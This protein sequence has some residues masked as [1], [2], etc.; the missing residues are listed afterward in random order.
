MELA[1]GELLL[2]VAS[3]RA[4]FTASGCACLHPYAQSGPSTQYLWFLFQKSP[5]KVGNWGPSQELPPR[6]YGLHVQAL[7]CYVEGP[8]SGYKLEDK[9]SAPFEM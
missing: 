3:Q 1:R 7:L 9:A 8:S 5:L 2:A 4:R 6:E